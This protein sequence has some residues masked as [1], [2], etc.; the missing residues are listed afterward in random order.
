MR[1]RSIYALVTSAL[2]AG[3]AVGVVGAP[4]FVGESLAS[5][6]SGVQL[7]TLPGSV[8]SKATP[9]IANGTVL[10][11]TQVGNEIIVGGSFTSVSPPGTTTGAVTRNYV[12]GFD[13]TTGAISTTFVPQLD[14][15]PVEGLYPGTAPNTVYLAGYFNKVNGVATKSIVLL[16]TLTG[17][18]VPGW[19]GTGFDGAGW[20]A[21]IA[22]G[23][24][25]VGG[26]FTKVNNVAH[27][28]LASL[29]PAT[30]KP[31]G[32]L[33]VQV[34]G[35]HNYTGQ[36]GQSNA[37]VGVHR[38]D[39]SPD[40]TLLVAVGNFKMV[41][42]VTHDQIVLVNLGATSGTTDTNWNTAGYSATCASGAYDTYMRD[43]QFSPDGTY[44]A[45]AATGGGTFS[46]NTDATRALCD[47]VTR[48]QTTATGTDVQP[49]WID[50]TGNDSFESIAVSGNAIYLGGH[51][52]WLN[53]SSGSDSPGEGSIPRPGLAAVDPVNGMP[54]S[55]NPGRNPRGAGA[56]A[57]LLTPNG[58]YV[59]SDTTF[60]GNSQYYRGRIAFF[61]VAGGENVTPA[62][63]VA[64]PANVYLA[65]QVPT[66]TNT[67]VLYRIDTGGP[68]IQAIDNGPNWLGDT[69]PINGVTING[70]TSTAGWNPVGSVDT[71]TVPP[72]TPSG[73]YSSERWG[74]SSSSEMSYTLAA[75][76]GTSADVRLYF[77]NQ[78]SGTSKVGQRIFNV[79]IDGSPFLTNY[80][81]VKDVGNEVGTMHDEVVTVPPSGQITIGFSHAGPDNPL[82]NGIEVLNAS[83]P[84]PASGQFDTLTDRSFNGT[85]AGPTNTVPNPAGITWSQVR[86]AFMVGNELFYGYSDGLL[87]SRTF[88]GTNVG[89]AV[90]ADPYQDPFWDNIQTGSG[91]TYEGTV[92]SL[93]GTEMQNVT[94]M[95]YSG[96][97]LFY[98]LVGQPTLHW[99]YFEPDDGALGSE[100]FTAG[101]TENFSTV[102]GMFIS[103]DTLYWA[104]SATGNLHSVAFD[105]GSP[106]GST[107]ALVSGPSLDGND[108]RARGEFPYNTAAP[109]A[110]FTGSCNQLA[111]SVDA[112]AST[113]PGSSITGYSWN[114]GDGTTENDATPTTSHTFAA[115]GTYTVTLTVTNAN[116]QSGTATQQLTATPVAAAVSFVG[117]A[118]TNGNGAT[119]TVT[120]PSNVAAGNAL[121]LLATAASSGATTAP[122]GWTQIDTATST[123]ITTTAW[124]K[125][126]TSTD[127]GSA[128]AVT[129]FGTAHGTVQLV[130]YAGTDPTAPI[131]AEAKLVKSGSST[132]ATT[133]TTAVPAGGDWVLSYWATKSSA[134][135]TWTAPAGQTVRSTANGSGSG[136]INSFVSDG[137]GPVPAGPAGGLTATTDQAGASFSTWT[138]VLAAAT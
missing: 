91:Q 132:S 47:T 101:G 63:P 73:I 64:L 84:P 13:A 55:W 104:D 137:G 89:P 2:L 42:G 25:L 19:V 54:Y 115:P 52:R 34:S 135:T 86:G 10:A 78:Y 27:A 14:A 72:T 85:A 60:I 94:G 50:Y 62:A 29:N 131:A 69:S 117:Q 136:R 39:V 22:Q 32:Y 123:A 65:G 125:V 92:P 99:R 130:A 17:Q 109:T 16:N 20:A 126:A 70:C 90:E 106:D 36:P 28:G 100:E 1:V 8:P 48:W 79:T 138:I 112:S 49:T 45:V 67:N 124:Y 133:P 102:Q 113:A 134:V 122:A 56:Y 6:S 51:E 68:T 118:S 98:S 53:N 24:L 26:T 81:I 111:C 83:V 127:A 58:L 77:A 82:I 108:W 15:G 87:Y 21:Q 110:S 35:H 31:D 41:D 5:P 93:F 12:F 46:Q 9:N 107:D 105:A 120:V 66:S 88:D 116:N 71:A 33:N 97:K 57:L 74:C 103:G 18:I 23:H 96:G 119:E 44:F 95:V 4:G 40:G 43:V 37:A 30:G 59:G 61:P 128:V 76:A 75:P 129:G 114:F 11:I 121:V 7:P 3:V 38:M 80:D